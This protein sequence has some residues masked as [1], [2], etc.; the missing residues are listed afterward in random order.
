MAMPRSVSHVKPRGRSLDRLNARSLEC[1][2]SDFD[3]KRDLERDP[4][5]FLRTRALPAPLMGAESARSAQM[6]DVAARPSR[7][8]HARD[9]HDVLGRLD[10]GP[11]FN[12]G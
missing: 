2:G 1:E 12:D 10:P 7:V 8:R 6:A 4:E 3:R 5:F 11:A 9:R